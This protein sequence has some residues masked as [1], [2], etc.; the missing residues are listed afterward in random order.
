MDDVREGSLGELE[1]PHIPTVEPNRG[2][3]GKMR[4][5]G[6]ESLRVTSQTDQLCP[7]PKLFVGMSECF[8]EPDPE[9]TRGTGDEDPTPAELLPQWTR[10][11]EHMLQIFLGELGKNHLRE[12]EKLS[13]RGAEAQI[14]ENWKKDCFKALSVEVFRN[15]VASLYRSLRLGVSARVFFF[16]YF[17][18]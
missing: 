13:R 11:R 7:Q 17:L 15:L 18:K 6:I 1:I 9:E 12:L 5:L 14:S 8:K 4:S 2:L 3:I 10:M 16:F